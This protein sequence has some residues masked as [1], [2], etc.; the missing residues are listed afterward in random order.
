M[1]PLCIDS[2]IFSQTYKVREQV[3]FGATVVAQVLSCPANDVPTHIRWILNDAVLPQTNI[4]G[5]TFDPNG[6]CEI[7]TFVAAMQQRIDEIDF[8]FDCFG[9]YTFNLTGDTITNGQFPK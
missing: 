1:L 5:C 9:N 8:A 4:A 6:L 2:L 7:D 3:P